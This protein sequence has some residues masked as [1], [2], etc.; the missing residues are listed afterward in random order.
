MSEKAPKGPWRP[1][2]YINY[3][4]LGTFIGG[5]VLAFTIEDAPVV[6][7]IV[8]AFASIFLSIGVIAKGVEVGMKSAWPEEE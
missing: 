7:I 4:I 6:G 3:G 2:T 5:I 1:D 8:L